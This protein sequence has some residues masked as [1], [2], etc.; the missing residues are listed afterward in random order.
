S[1]PY[2]VRKR[3][4]LARAVISEPRLLMLDEPAAGLSETETTE[5]AELV[6]GLR[7]R[8]TVMLVEHHMDFV[9][10]LCDEL[11]V[12]DFGEVIARGTPTEVRDDPAVQRAYLG[13]AVNGDA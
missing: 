12:L 3:V 6:R 11:V 1:L 10:N 13:E 4:A 8:T 5:L 7:D 9:M 2:G